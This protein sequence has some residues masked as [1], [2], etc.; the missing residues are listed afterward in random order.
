MTPFSGLN[1][2]LKTPADHFKISGIEKATLTNLLT[3]ASQD[4]QCYPS[5]KKL[6]QNTG[7]SESAIKRSIKKLEELGLI[8]KR[9]R[10]SSSGPTSNLYKINITELVKDKQKKSTNT[11]QVKPNSSFLAQDGNYYSCPADYYKSKSA[12]TRGQLHA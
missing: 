9:R 7:F 6:S 12:N 1:I 5:I 8:T 11:N 10:Y 3:F 2:F 4:Y